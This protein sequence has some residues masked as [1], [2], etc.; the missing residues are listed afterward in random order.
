[1]Q[2]M[3]GDTEK[4]KATIEAKRTRIEQEKV[5][6]MKARCRESS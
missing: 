1:M 3:V 5:Q 6:K 2:P 4:E